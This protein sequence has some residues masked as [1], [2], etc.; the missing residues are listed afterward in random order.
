MGRVDLYKK[1]LSREEF[2][3]QPPEAQNGMRFN[4]EGQE[5]S[6]NPYELERENQKIVSDIQGHINNIKKM[7]NN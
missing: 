2:E 4:Q 1:P 6:Y 5:E 7:I 3:N